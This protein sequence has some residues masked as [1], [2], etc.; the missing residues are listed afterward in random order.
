MFELI[1][2]KENSMMMKEILIFF[3]TSKNQNDEHDKI[4]RVILIAR[5]AAYQ[6]L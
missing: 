6:N 3:R 5:H 1:S 4:S 2:S